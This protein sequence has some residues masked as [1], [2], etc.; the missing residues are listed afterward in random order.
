M[1]SFGDGR[2]VGGVLV[3]LLVLLGFL[4]NPWFGES[5]CWGVFLLA[6]ASP[7]GFEGRTGRTGEPW[8][9][10]YRFYGCEVRGARCEVRG[11]RCEGFWGFFPLWWV[12]G[13]WG[14]RG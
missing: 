5:L 9:L 11:A 7:D 6:G 4:E 10:C 8:V 12:V 3:M 14:G 2:G 13:F 1:L